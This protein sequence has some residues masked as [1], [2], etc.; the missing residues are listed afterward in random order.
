MRNFIRQNKV[1]PVFVSALLF[2]FS[3]LL[4]SFWAFI[5]IDPHHDGIM[6]KPAVDVLQGKM[7][8]RDSFTQYGALSTLLQAGFCALFGKY[9]A[10]LRLF[11][12]ITYSGTFV[13]FYLTARR[14]F[15]APWVLYVLLLAFIMAPFYASI[16]Y[17]W[18]SVFA[19]FFTTLTCYLLTF[20]E[21]YPDSGY[22]WAG[23]GIT[24]ILSFWCRQPCGL[25][26]GAVVGY[27]LIFKWYQNRTIIDS[28]RRLIYVSGGA[29]AV[30]L[31]LL[32]WIIFNGA[33]DE[34]VNQSFSF[35]VRFAS[36]VDNSS[37]TFW[38]FVVLDHLIASIT[39][40]KFY[41]YVFGVTSIVCVALLYQSL[42]RRS[43]AFVPWTLL[44]VGLVSLSSL[45]QYYP[46]AESNHFYWAA[47]PAFI[48][49][50]YGISYLVDLRRQPVVLKYAAVTIGICLAL[51]PMYKFAKTSWEDYCL[52]E[53]SSFSRLSS[54][55]RFSRPGPL[56]GLFIPQEYADGWNR[57]S[58]AISDLPAEH[59]NRPVL[60]LTPDALY[61]LFF[62]NQNNWH[63]ASMNWGNSIDSE[64][65]I[66]VERMLKK[67]NSI[68]ILY[69]DQGLEKSV[70]DQGYQPW[71]EVKLIFP[72]VYYFQNINVVRN[73]PNGRVL[74]IWLP[75]DFSAKNSADYFVRQEKSV[76]A[77]NPLAKR[78]G[79]R[80][81]Q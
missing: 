81:E 55:E 8:F 17:I 14:L 73:Y 59:Q 53:P 50:G 79:S 15:D 37:D 16:F 56:Q 67:K 54:L 71:K 48:L 47:L 3:F 31:P 42:F 29:I 49:Y 35:A 66:K 24:S 45:H 25:A 60:N 22:L 4:F 78:I 44:G 63:R 72:N 5:D 18:S 64:Y 74:A 77:T 9:L 65:S 21:D 51:Y 11:T 62:Q 80:R 69:K 1:I 75:D 61:P 40:S 57:L 19:L 46:V 39:I 32:G 38:L 20:T 26:F 68:V 6:M 41:C 34:F 36:R 33:W 27:A 23:L 43:S 76:E 7:L 13:L 10:A 28:I 12:L 70:L 58:Q 52:N 30:S 2:L